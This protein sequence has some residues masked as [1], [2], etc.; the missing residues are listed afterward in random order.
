MSIS[1]TIAIVTDHKV[2]INCLVTLF[3]LKYTIIIHLYPTT[4]IKSITII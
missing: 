4:I 2:T 1:N 3:L